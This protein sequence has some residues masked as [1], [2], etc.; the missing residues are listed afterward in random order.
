MSESSSTEHTHP[1]KQDANT[2]QPIITDTVEPSITIN[3]ET[4]SPTIITEVGLDGGDTGSNSN[5]IVEPIKVGSS[6]PAG[7]AS[8]EVNTDPI[9]ITT[10]TG[11]TVI[12]IILVFAIVILLTWMFANSTIN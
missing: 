1:S 3:T 8:T 9:I 12:A 2:T 10:G 6:T 5:E 4:T 7:L 11:P